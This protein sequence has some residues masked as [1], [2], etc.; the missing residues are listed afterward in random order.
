MDVCLVL[1]VA[2]AVAVWLGDSMCM[3]LEEPRDEGQR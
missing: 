1:D 3:G 2:V